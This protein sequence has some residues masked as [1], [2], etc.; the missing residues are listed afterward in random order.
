[1]QLV[2]VI[3][4]R[5]AVR[6]ATI[7]FTATSITRFPF[8]SLYGLRLGVFVGRQLCSVRNHNLLFAV[9]CH[10]SDNLGLNLLLEY[11]RGK[12]VQLGAVGLEANA[13]T[14]QIALGGAFVF[15]ERT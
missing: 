5:K 11:L 12:V 2:V 6:A 9:L 4:V 7:T 3:A 1:M 14:L 8:I 10:V 15:L 13:Y